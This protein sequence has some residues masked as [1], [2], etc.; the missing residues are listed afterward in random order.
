MEKESFV[1]SCRREAG[2]QPPQR[3]AKY[4]R[5]YDM[6]KHC[7]RNPCVEGSLTGARPR[8]KARI[9]LPP[10]V[11]KRAPLDLPTARPLDIPTARTVVDATV[12]EPA[13]FYLVLVDRMSL[14]K[15]PNKR[16]KANNKDKYGC[17]ECG[18]TMLHAGDR[19][20]YNPSEQC[21]RPAATNLF[22]TP[23]LAQVRTL[24]WPIHGVKRVCCG[25]LRMLSQVFNMQNSKPTNGAPS[26]TDLVTIQVNLCKTPS[27]TCVCARAHMQHT[28]IINMCCGCHRLILADSKCAHPYYSAW[29][30]GKTAQ[31]HLCWGGVK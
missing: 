16:N 14:V 22:G 12:A 8:A 4:K 29:R 18:S 20:M 19:L 1:A 7:G 31:R 21:L 11:E 9:D 27:H 28:R 17:I 3:P 24:T 10:V 30:G 13:P 23:M 25:E 26:D 2:A 5:A 15:R 6:R